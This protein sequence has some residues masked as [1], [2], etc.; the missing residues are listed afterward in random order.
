MIDTA[1]LTRPTVKLTDEDGNAFYVIGLTM[2][3]MKAAGW[4]K[5]AKDEF[6]TE[7]MDGDYN[8]LLRTV[9]KYCDVD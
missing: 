7:A 8:H 6:V 5:T 9:M 3:A 2:K 4:P 1:N